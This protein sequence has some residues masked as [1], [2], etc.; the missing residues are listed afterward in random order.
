MGLISKWAD[1]HDNFANATVALRCCV[2]AA[3][4]TTS[5]HLRFK[6]APSMACPEDGSERASI[7][8]WQLKGHQI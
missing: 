3:S 7:R 4:D 2:S 8:S 5:T 1:K 6:I